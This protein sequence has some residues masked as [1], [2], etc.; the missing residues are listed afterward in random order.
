[1]IFRTLAIAALVATTAALASC[2]VQQPYNGQGGGMQ[3]LFGAVAAP[4]PAQPAW[5]PPQPAPARAPVQPTGTVADA[6]LQRDV[7]KKIGA[8]EGAVGGSTAPTL[9]T[10]RGNGKAGATFIEV[11]TVNS[12]GASVDYGVKLTPSDSG[13]VDFSVERLTPVTKSVPKK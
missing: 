11:W 9:V 2:A 6:T 13:G 5:T 12:N 1:M 3:G 10:T 8:D 4:P 7:L